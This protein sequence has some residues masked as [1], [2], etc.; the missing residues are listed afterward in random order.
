MPQ[1]LDSIIAMTR[2]NTRLGLRLAEAW[3]ES[4]Q[5]L[6]EIG[7]RGAAEAVEEARLAVTRQEEKQP[8]TAASVVTGHLQDFVGELEAVR[9]AAALQVNDAFEEWRDSWKSALEIDTA[10]PLGNL[11]KPS[12]AKPRQ[13][14]QEA[15]G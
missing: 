3:R 11:L 5:K 1:P 2:A 14:R 4:G 9:V 12:S 13:D 10:L 7:G 15:A 6:I 8:A